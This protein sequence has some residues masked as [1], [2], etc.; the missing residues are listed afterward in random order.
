VNDFKPNSH[1][2]KAEQK[3]AKPERQKL[4][5]VVRGT[6]RTKK[7]TEL[8]KFASAFVPQNTS[9]VKE[10]IL[11]DVVF[12]TIK[13]TVWEIFS[14]GV[15]MLLYGEANRGKKNGIPGS[16]INYNGISSG[17]SRGT[18]RFAETRTANKYSYDDVYVDT[19]GEAEEVLSQLD[20]LIEAYGK[21]SV[22][23]LYDL[24]GITGD[25]TDCKYGWKDLATAG[26][27]R[28]RD[29]YKFKLPKV[30]PLD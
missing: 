24:V 28:T 6:A 27:I 26:V 5:K 22:L 11:W 29:G 2:F 30:S 9:N 7:K 16:R 23:D 12:P 17:N 20:D 8:S 3:A 25:H 13:D 18:D 10:Y 19:K 4:E 1:R 14:N 21:A 15:H